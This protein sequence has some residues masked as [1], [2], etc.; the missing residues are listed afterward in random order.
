MQTSRTIFGLLLLS[1]IISYFSD[2]LLRTITF[3]C[4]KTIKLSTNNNLFNVNLKGARNKYDFSLKVDLFGLGIPE[5]GVAVLAYFVL[6]GS[7]GKKFDLLKLS[8][9][10]KTDEELKREEEMKN[11]KDLAYK[12]RRVRS[13]KRINRLVEMKDEK[14]L[15]RLDKLNDSK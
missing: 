3:G 10:F 1:S 8:D 2:A 13:W 4:T 12:E 11:M 14:I 15:S 9:V 5:I 7:E 6:F